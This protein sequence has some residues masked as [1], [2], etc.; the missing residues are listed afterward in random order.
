[1]SV[2]N[3]FNVWV[4]Y[5]AIRNVFGKRSS[6]LAH[7]P[8]GLPWMGG[9]KRV[10]LIHCGDT[11]S[12]GHDVDDDR[13]EELND[14]FSDLKERIDE[15]DSTESGLTGSLHKVSLLLRRGSLSDDE[16]D[17]VER[18]LDDL[19]SRIDSC[20]DQMDADYDED[21]YDSYDDDDLEEMLDEAFDEDLFEDD[22]FDYGYDDFFDDDNY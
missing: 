21:G 1:M 17:I 3:L 15:F 10:S 16:L 7:R 9:P 6:P 13:H 8:H 18:A 2:L 22:G 4:V 19:E 12:F 5:D 11:G 14:R 20:E